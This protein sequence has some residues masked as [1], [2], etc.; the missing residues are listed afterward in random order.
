MKKNDQESEINTKSGR[1]G[2]RNSF[3][4]DEKEYDEN[5]L[6]IYHVPSFLVKLFEIVDSK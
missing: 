3:S 5:G 1:K 2:K 4:D 6:S